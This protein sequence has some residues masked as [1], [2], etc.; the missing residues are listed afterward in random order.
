MCTL[1][2][3]P[4]QLQLDNDDDMLDWL[5]EE[6]ESESCPRLTDNAGMLSG[7]DQQPEIDHD[8]MDDWYATIRL[9]G[10]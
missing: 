8:L 10:I 2:P 6:C 7:E 5:D 4:I 3:P 9:L 1:C